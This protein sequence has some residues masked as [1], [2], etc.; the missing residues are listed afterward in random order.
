MSLSATSSNPYPGQEITLSCNLS[1]NTAFPVPISAFGPSGVG[2]SGGASSSSD[3][4]SGNSPGAEQSRRLRELISSHF[5]LNINWLHNG[6]PIN[7][8]HR[9]RR[10][11]EESL[12]I[13]DF[14]GPD[15]NGLYQCSVRLTAP[16]Y[17]EESFMAGQLIKTIGKLQLCFNQNLAYLARSIIM[18]L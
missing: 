14:R 9:K 12:V 1:T 5:L 11:A 10:S 15:D 3:A 17:D 8:N 18:N 4:S 16:D 6:R 2:P 7:F 13:G